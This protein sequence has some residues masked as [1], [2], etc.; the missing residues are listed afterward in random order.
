MSI[1]VRT[2]FQS[3][4]RWEKPP[5]HPNDHVLDVEGVGRYHVKRIAKGNRT[6]R[7]W[8]NGKP[9][10]FFGTRDIVIAMVDRAVRARIVAQEKIAAQEEARED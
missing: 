10:S 4:F 8:L 5:H 6:F 7:A 9:T 3:M 2:P 1:V